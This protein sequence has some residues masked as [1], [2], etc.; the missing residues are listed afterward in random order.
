MKK[1]FSATALL[2]CFCILA[3]CGGNTETPETPSAETSSNASVEENIATSSEDTSE[4]DSSTTPSE[5]SS[6]EELAGLWADAVYTENTTFGEGAL[7]VTVEVKA[8]DKSIDLTIKTD[9]TILGDALMEHGLVE[10]D[11]GQFGLYIKKVNGITADFDVDQSY[12]AFYKNGEMMMTGV[13][14]AEIKDGE[15]Y[16]LVYTKS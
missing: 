4:S 6:K 14:G 12:W 16:E 5:E 7:T 8:E 15:H 13:D 3:A 9:K 1:V 11:E 2:L 10:G